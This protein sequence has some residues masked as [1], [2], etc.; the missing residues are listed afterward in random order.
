VRVP[1][2]LIEVPDF[3]DGGAD[4]GKRT[5]ETGERDGVRKEDLKEGGR[6]I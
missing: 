6:K 4:N 2:K 1:A 3:E 5:E